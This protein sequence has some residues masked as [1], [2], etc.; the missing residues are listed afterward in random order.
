MYLVIVRHTQRRTRGKGRETHKH[1]DRVVYV[2]IKGVKHCLSI[3]SFEFRVTGLSVKKQQQTK[4]M[5]MT[6]NV[7]VIL[8]LIFYFLDYNDSFVRHRE[9]KQILYYRRKKRNK[10]KKNNK[11]MDRRGF[12]MR[13]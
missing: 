10:Y 9:N 5:V 13:S 2:T 1:T 3:R 4:Q 12:A 11:K 7:C 8:V 6:D